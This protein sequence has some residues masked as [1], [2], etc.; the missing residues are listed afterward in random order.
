MM[1]IAFVG[2]G[3]FRSGCEGMDNYLLSMGGGGS[4]YVLVVPTAAVDAPD[5]ASENGISYFSKLGVEA[6]SLMVLDRG[7]AN[8]EALTNEIFEATH[9]YFSG[10]FPDYLL[11]T[12][13]GSL[14]VQRLCEWYRSGGILIGSSAG[15]MVMGS[16]MWSPRDKIWV[17][18][19][20]FGEGFAVLPHHE[21]RDAGVVAKTLWNNLPQ[22]IRVFGV[23]AQ[24]C[25]VRNQDC[26]R[27]E[28]LGNVTVYK[29]N[30][31]QIYSCGQW[32]NSGL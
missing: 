8:D 20:G 24:T 31:Q 9:V 22:N 15:A 2:G 28:G 19:L 13:Q 21:E 12:L 3:E 1:H 7:H 25:C 16:Y 6:K 14:F 29:P 30:G 17:E 23:D 27:V 4:T 26:W 32:I 5:R 10:G 11:E 18:G